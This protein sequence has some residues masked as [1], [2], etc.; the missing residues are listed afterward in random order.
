MF[1]QK[2]MIIIV[3][4][5]WTPAEGWPIVKLT[6]DSWAGTSS[7]I[8]DNPSQVHLFLHKIVIGCFSKKMLVSSED[9]RPYGEHYLQKFYWPI[10]ILFFLSICDLHSY[11]IYHSKIAFIAIKSFLSKL[12]LWSLFLIQKAWC[13]VP[14]TPTLYPSRRKKE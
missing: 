12:W 1:C 11:K 3:H 4:D 14:Y 9:C 6:R 10:I 5:E 2:T 8:L 7:K 13:S